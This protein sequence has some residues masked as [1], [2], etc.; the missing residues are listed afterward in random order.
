MLAPVINIKLQ[1]NAPPNLEGRICE[2]TDV[3][4]D[5]EK[6]IIDHLDELLAYLE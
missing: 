6:W 3:P 5:V 2:K 1:L 4:V